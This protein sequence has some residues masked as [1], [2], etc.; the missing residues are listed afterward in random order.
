[1]SDEYFRLTLGEQTDVDEVVLGFRKGG[2]YY[3]LAVL[4][5]PLQAEIRKE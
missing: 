2:E 4:E 1:M 5:P 3:E